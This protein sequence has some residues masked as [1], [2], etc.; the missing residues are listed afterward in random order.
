MSERVN[1]FTRQFVPT[2]AHGVPSDAGCE[3]CAIEE[4]IRDKINVRVHLDPPN[5]LAAA[6]RRIEELEAELKSLAIADSGFDA[7]LKALSAHETCA[8]SYDKPDD[9]CMHH[10]PMVLHLEFELAK[11]REIIAGLCDRWTDEDEQ[12][13]VIEKAEKWMEGK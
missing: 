9:V 12:E 4:Q 1:P 10:S 13:R 7:K 6:N 8:C 11:A 3:E 5:D 2:C